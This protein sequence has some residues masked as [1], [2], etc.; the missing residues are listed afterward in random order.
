MASRRQAAAGAGA[1]DVFAQEHKGDVRLLKKTKAKVAQEPAAETRRPLVEVGNVINGR[2]APAD[3]S[4][5]KEVAA[6]EANK[7]VRAIK[8]HKENNRVKPQ[9]IVISSDSENEKKNQ[10]KRAA[11]RR[12]PIN[13]LTK[14][15]SKCSR[16]SDG[17]ISSPKKAPVAYNIDASDAHNELAVVDYVEDIYRFYK[18]TESTCRPLC[19]YM[20][21]QPDINERMRA[22]LIDWIIEV[23]HRLILMPE[24]LYLTVYIIDQYL[25]MKNVLRKDLQ[26]IGVSAMLIACKYEEI[27]APL[28]QDLLCISDNSFSREQVLRKEKSILNTLQWNLTVPTLYMFM[29]RYLKAAMGDK[30]LENMAFFYAELSLVQYTMLQYPPSKTAAA[31]VYA[32][33]CTL[34][35]S[36]RWNDVLEHHTGLAE[37]QLLDCAMRLASL[38]SAAP[39]SKQKVVYVKYSNPK[40]G[41]VSLYA[42]SK[43]LMI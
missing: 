12:S 27:W 43:R 34:N 3:P 28:V 8:Q 11:S 6:V 15:L 10:A 17:V 7:C 30:E 35:M 1:G 25:S 23:H 40:L 42:P 36:P 14:I 4:R 21:S 9:V 19:T 13:T 32:A 24:T 18:R 16:A 39:G 26:L 22:I 31:A 5:H 37:W 41:T 38:H 20:I 33:R 2:H 29:V